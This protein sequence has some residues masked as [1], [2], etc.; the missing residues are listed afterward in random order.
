MKLV[1]AVIRPETLSP[2]LSAL[3]DFGISGLTVSEVNGCGRQKGQTQ[4]YRGAAIK[5]DLIPK[6]KLE[7]VVDDATVSG[8]VDLLADIASTGNPGDGKM[9]VAP[10]DR[11]VRMSD[12]A[13]AEAAL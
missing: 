7:L 11:V 4:M 1:T 3:A 10:V 13:E 8:L 9:W 2:V 6:V 12:R 5:V